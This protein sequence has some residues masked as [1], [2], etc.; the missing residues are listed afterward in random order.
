M[1][2][3]NLKL[4]LTLCSL[5]SVFFRVTVNAQKD[6]LNNPREEACAKYEYPDESVKTDL[7]GL[8]SQMKFMPGCT[9]SSECKE[10]SCSP[11]TVL[12]DIC[13]WDMG[14]MKDCANYNK[15][16]ANGTR[17]EA[18]KEE[19]FLKGDLTTIAVNSAVKSICYEM[20]EMAGCEKCEFAE[21]K[22]YADCDLLRVYAQLCR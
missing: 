11:W 19:G 1:S 21:G 17:V 3:P 14:K 8:C 6:C 5:V 9:L 13:R 12:T 4:I 7:N 10:P 16:C 20:P 15:L 2:F 18:C 22:T